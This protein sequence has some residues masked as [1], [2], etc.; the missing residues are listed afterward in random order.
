MEIVKE[1]SK[2]AYEY[3]KYNIIQKEV[4]KKLISILEKKN[5][6]NILDLGAG[7]GEV[8]KNLLNQNVNFEQ[9]VALDFSS[10]ML[11]IHPESLNVTKICIDFNKK[12]SFSKFKNEK[13]NLLI[14]SSALQWSENLNRVLSNISTLS[15]EYYFSFFTS[16]TFKTLHETVGISSP[17]YSKEKIIEA[18]DI[19][20]IY[21]FEVKAYRLDFNSVH[22][23]LRYIKRSGVGGG[24]KQLSYSEMKRLM[25]EYPLKYLEFE[26]IFV[27]AKSKLESNSSQQRKCYN[28]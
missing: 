24:V 13:F 10:E 26:V 28:E 17:I 8:Y 25:R 12:D 23:M 16:N 6:E 5:Y 15:D 20:F 1:F 4:A 18:L 3:K 2:F 19:L 22:D 9:F 14:S 21:E 27:K 11:K 7:D